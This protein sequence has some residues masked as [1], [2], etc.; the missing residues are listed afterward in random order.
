MVLWGCKSRPTE[1]SNFHNGTFTHQ[2]NY[3]TISVSRND[4]TELDSTLLNGTVTKWKVAWMNPCEY[5]LI[6]MT[7]WTL[8]KHHVVSDQLYIH[9]TITE[10]GL[11]YY[12][13][14][15]IFGTT[16]QTEKDFTYKAIK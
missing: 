3:S 1:C 13:A 9:V 4:S 15:E 10:T 2:T 14:H 8:S 11:D 5:T 7:G 16:K 12:N 6:F